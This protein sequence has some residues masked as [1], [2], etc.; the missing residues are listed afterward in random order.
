MA[1]RKIPEETP[2]DKTAPTAESDSD[3]DFSF[4]SPVEDKPKT[5]PEL[6]RALVE[7]G[8]IGAWKDRTDIGDSLEYARLL[9]K[10]ASERLRGQ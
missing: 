2:G 6:Y 8:F 5:G 1:T 10:R 7:S 3:D 4:A 9:R